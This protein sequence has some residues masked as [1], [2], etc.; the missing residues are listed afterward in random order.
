MKILWTARS[1]PFP[2]VALDESAFHELLPELISNSGHTW[3]FGRGFARA[4]STPAQQWDRLV[5]ELAVTTSNNRTRDMLCGFIGGLNERSPEIVN[6][7]LDKAVG[8]EILSGFYPALECAK[9]IDSQAVIRLQK[10]LSIGI[11]PINSYNVLSGG[12]ATDSIPLSDF[13]DLIKAIAAR[14]NGS[15]VAAEIVHMRL[16]SYGKDEAVDP[17]IIALGRKLLGQ[18]T[19]SI[20]HNNEDYRWGEIIK[21]CLPGSE[22]EAVAVANAL[23]VRFKEWSSTWQA[24]ISY[25]NS[26]LD[27]LFLVQPQV[28][29]D[30]LLGDPSDS[31]LY[32]R[33][34]AIRENRN[35]LDTVGFEVLSSWCAQDPERRYVRLAGV[36]TLFDE[37]VP[38]KER[39]WTDV[40]LRLLRDAPNRAEVVKQYIR[41]LEPSGWVGSF[42]SAMQANV[43][44][45]DVLETSFDQTLI[46][47]VRNERNRLARIVD[48]QK[49]R[50][51]DS[52][53]EFY[54]MFE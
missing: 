29:L 3:A 9:G 50:E 5:A 22:G 52:R 6:A 46:E 7:L 44:M 11:S 19:F 36:V 39:R 43:R 35:P 4:C 12:R 38:E 42:A 53:R 51:A 21:K 28:A 25:H 40:A 17:K 15:S 49:R 26:V 20:R 31:G 47:V 34:S 1:R 33:W 27:A 16:H 41:R 8:S 32:Y 18:S 10:S 30:I 13:A 2:A 48:E 45:L 54:Q 23:C 14:E 37:N 24:Q